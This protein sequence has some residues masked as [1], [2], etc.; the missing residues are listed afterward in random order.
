MSSMRLWL[1]LLSIAF[2]SVFSGYAAA[3]PEISAYYL[4]GPSAKKGAPDYYATLENLEELS[5]KIAAEGSNFNNLMLSFVQPSLINYTPNSLTCTGLFGYTCVKEKELPMDATNGAADF[6]RLKGILANLRAHGV[7]TY[8]AVGGW[9]FSCHPD[10]YDKT[11]KKQNACGPADEVYD[12]FP[13]PSKTIPR[14]DSNITGSAAEGAYRNIVQLAND[15]GA[16]GIDVDYEEFWHADINAKFWTLNPD[17]IIP[18]VENGTPQRLSDAEL[19]Q[20]GLS[21]DV[22]N[23]QMEVDSRSEKYARAMPLTVDKFAAILKTLDTSIKRINPSMKLSTAAP[24]SGGIPNMSANWG[25]VASNAGI[26]G[27]AW[28]GGNLYG[29]IY[30]TALLYKEEIDK[31]SH[32][33][34]MSYDLSQRDCKDGDDPD[35]EIP[36]DLVG[37]VS[38]YYNQFATWLKTGGGL[39]ADSW[40]T[41]SNVKLSGSRTYAQASI[42]PR[43]LLISP[44]ITVGFEVGQ[45]A[46]GNLV[47]TKDKLT[48]LVDETMKYGQAG[49]IMW[50]LFKD[51]RYDQKNWH[52]TWATPKDVLKEACTKMGLAGEHYNCK[53]NVP[54]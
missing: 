37:Q 18:P 49:I 16:A 32:V 30:N 10:I 20:L 48:L 6:K 33:G 42:Q 1:V 14:F 53:T 54:R 9:N 44:P 36:C 8:I 51:V 43:K 13:N 41:T 28:R 11:A 5:E 26:Y 4:S 19:K 39:P 38:F 29:L 50:D 22:Y 24:A 21:E 45:P 31:L 15:L 12:V 27:G 25:T 35:S 3:T 34:I 52:P 23:P 7:Q 47:L 46:T 17:T 40:V 2:S